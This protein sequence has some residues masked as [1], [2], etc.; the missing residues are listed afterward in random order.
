LTGDGWPFVSSLRACEGDEGGNRER[1]GPRAPCAAPGH[2]PSA[3]GRRTGRP[4]GGPERRGWRRRPR[5]RPRRRRPRRAGRWPPRR[6]RRGRPSAGGV[7]GLLRSRSALRRR[8]SLSA[9]E[10]CS[11]EQ[12]AAATRWEH[13]AAVV[14]GARRRRGRRVGLVLDD[15]GR[16]LLDLGSGGRCRSRRRSRQAGSPGRPRQLDECPWSRCRRRSSVSGGRRTR[17]AARGGRRGRW[18]RPRWWSSRRSPVGRRLGR[19]RTISRRPGRAEGWPV[20]QRS[21][22]TMQASRSKASTAASSSA[23]AERAAACSPAWS[24]ARPSRVR[25]GGSGAGGS[26]PG[27]SA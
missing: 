13:G 2:L 24:W 17:G 21:G 9:C 5:P 26:P 10:A 1:C 14:E 4:T 6:C 12:V 15:D 16:H 25:P 11:A 20:P 27:G 8:R 19:R 23:S 7:G 18:R 3:F 22:R